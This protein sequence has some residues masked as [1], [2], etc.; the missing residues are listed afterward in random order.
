MHLV[1]NGLRLGVKLGLP[2]T[3][4]VLARVAH[5]ELMQARLEA[6]KKDQPKLLLP[7]SSND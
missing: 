4:M 3:T 6:P 1:S 2:Y 7:I 5:S